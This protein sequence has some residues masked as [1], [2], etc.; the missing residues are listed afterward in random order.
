MTCKEVSSES[1]PGE[2][3][4]KKGCPPD[5]LPKTFRI[6]GGSDQPASSGD[7]GRRLSCLVV[8][9][10]GRGG[11]RLNKINNSRDTAVNDCR[12]PV[13]IPKR[14]WWSNHDHLH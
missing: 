7:T 10:C 4:L 2:T 14:S 6:L 5:P 12:Q 1:F 8:T 13:N 11:L 9:T 3:L